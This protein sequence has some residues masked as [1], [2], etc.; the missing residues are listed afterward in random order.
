MRRSVDC[1]ESLTGIERQTFTSIAL[2]SSTHC[3]ATLRLYRRQPTKPD[4][5]KYYIPILSHN[6]IYHHRCTLA[7]GQIV[8]HSREWRQQ[9]LGSLDVVA[10]ETDKN[11]RQT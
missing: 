3:K 1:A 5:C 8:L 2:Y 6:I 4:K 7:V 11:R 9:L 10:E